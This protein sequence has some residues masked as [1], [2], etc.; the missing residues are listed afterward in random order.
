M[1]NVSRGLL[2][3]SVIIGDPHLVAG[4]LPAEGAISSLTLAELATGPH[5]TDDPHERALRQLR[6]Q[7]VEATFEVLPFDRAAARAYG[8]IYA[9]VRAAG[10][11]PRGRIVDLQIA[12]VALAHAIPLFTGNPDDFRGLEGIVDVVPV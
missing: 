4:L 1:S 2:D 12:A 5:A 7:Q 6:L 11:R 8:R 10:R 3:T 9:A